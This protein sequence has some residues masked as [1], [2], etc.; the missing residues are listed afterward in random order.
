MTAVAAK[1]APPPA[2]P[3][4]AALYLSI[5]I[6]LMGFGVLLPVFPFWGRALAATAIGVGMFNPAFQTLVAA[7]TGDDDRGVINGLMQGG[8]AVG[9]II[10]PAVSGLIFQKFGPAMP[11]LA[12]AA[13]MLLAF[14]VAVIVGRQLAARQR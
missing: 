3:P 9:R 4:L 8:S 1:P 6:G 5:F 11:F 13:L 10:G 2:A 12:G 7:T 14:G